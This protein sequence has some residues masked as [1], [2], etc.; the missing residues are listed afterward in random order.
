MNQTKA[1]VDALLTAAGLGTDALELSVQPLVV[2]T[3]D[4]V[5]LFDTGNGPAAMLSSSMATA[6]VAPG[7]VTD[8][9]IS[10]S[11]GDHVNGLLGSDG[12]LPFGAPVTHG[13][14]GG[15]RRRGFCD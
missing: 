10:H 4:R 8:I 7:A 15:S 6:G 2:R 1:E 5:L 11:H 12:A 9:F 14:E 13:H 3:P